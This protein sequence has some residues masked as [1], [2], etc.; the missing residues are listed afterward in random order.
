VTSDSPSI[1]VRRYEAS[2]YP[3][4]LDLY[5]DDLRSMGDAG[6]FPVSQSW[7]W[8][9]TGSAGFLLGGSSWKPGPGI[10]AVTYRYEPRTNA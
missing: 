7:G 5:E 2:S 9:A 10:L 6:W 4:A 1:V 8:D 3:E